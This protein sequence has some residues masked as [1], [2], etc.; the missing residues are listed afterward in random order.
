M[1]TLI[2]SVSG[3]MLR[4]LFDGFDTANNPRKRVAEIGLAV[5]IFTFTP[6]NIIYNL[7]N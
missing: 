6:T 2:D 7:N 3:A 5:Q 1:E 4:H